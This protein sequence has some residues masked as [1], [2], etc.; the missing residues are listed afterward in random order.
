VEVFGCA[1]VLAVG[2][3]AQRMLAE[4]GIDAIPLRHP[5]Q[6]GKPEFVRGLRE[7]LGTRGDS[8]PALFQA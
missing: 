7:A 3:T 4:Q 1:T 5:S 2:R 8:S 6:G